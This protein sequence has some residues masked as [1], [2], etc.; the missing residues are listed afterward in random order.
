MCEDNAYVVFVSSPLVNTALG[1]INSIYQLFPVFLLYSRTNQFHH[2]NS[3]AM[4]L[5]DLIGINDFGG[6]NEK[7]L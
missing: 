7:Y 4:R 2:V 1:R 6:T 5:F 3:F